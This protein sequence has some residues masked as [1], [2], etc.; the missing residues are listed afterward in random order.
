MFITPST[1]IQQ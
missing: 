1:L